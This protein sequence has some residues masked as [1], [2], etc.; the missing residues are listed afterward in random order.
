MA[1]IEPS[2]IRIIN[3]WK[4]NW[5]YR[6]LTI[7]KLEIETSERSDSIKPTEA[8][9]TRNKS[10]FR[11]CII[12]WIKKIRIFRSYIQWKRLPLLRSSSE[13]VRTHHPPQLHQLLEHYNIRPI[14]RLLN[15]QNKI[16]FQIYISYEIIFIFIIKIELF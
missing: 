10:S 6:Q 2:K 15:W 7:I 13:D 11:I 8:L 9:E 5:M 16:K 3:S 14:L 1:K 12:R 4:S